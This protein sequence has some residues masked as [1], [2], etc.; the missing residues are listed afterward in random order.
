MFKVKEGAS[1]RWFMAAIEDQ[2][3]AEARLR[4]E[5]G[6][7]GVFEC[8]PIPTQVVDFFQ[9]PKGKVQRWMPA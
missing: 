3:E 5:I 8:K 7:G 6:D 9:L 1:V 2:S 4:A